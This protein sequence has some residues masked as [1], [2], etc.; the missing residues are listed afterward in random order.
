MSRDEPSPR[1]GYRIVQG[2][3]AVLVLVSAALLIDE[4][5]EDGWS[6]MSVAFLLNLITFTCLF[7]IFRRADAQK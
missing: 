3:C 6:K 4:A 1:A 7:F 5:L 2:L